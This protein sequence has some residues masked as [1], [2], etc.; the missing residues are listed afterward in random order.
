MHV[1]S[2]IMPFVH[3]FLM[4]FP[5]FGFCPGKAIDEAISRVIK[6]CSEVRERLKQGNCGVFARRQ[7]RRPTSCYGGAQLS[8]DLS[9]AFDL[10]PRQVMHDALRIM[11]V[12]EDLCILILHLHETSKYHVEHAGR[13]ASF[14]MKRG[15]RQ[16]CTLA[17]TLFAAFMVYFSHLLASRT[18]SAWVEK[19]PTMFAD[20]TH[21]DWLIDSVDSMHEMAKFV[22]ETYTLFQELGMK[23]NPTKSVLVIRVKGRAAKSWIKQR[24]LKKKKQV[25]INLGTVSDPLL[26]PLADRTVY[27]GVVISYSNFEMQTVQH[28]IQVSSM[29]RQRLIKILHSSRTIDFQHRLRL[30]CACARSSTAYGVHAVG[31]TSKSLNRL[32]QYEIRHFRASARSPVHLTREPNDVFLRRQP[33]QEYFRKLLQGR[34]KKC[35]NESI[36][37]H[38]AKVLNFL[39]QEVSQDTEMGDRS[40]VLFPIAQNAGVSCPTCGTH[41]LDQSSMRKHHAKKHKISSVN[42]AG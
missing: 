9:Q 33:I 6:H 19:F 8:V 40:E 1:K 20:D 35:Q 21:S 10:L 22:R 38:F 23:V 16:G 37:Q 32:Q 28:R 42:P 7:G 5:Q 34:I 25:L 17:P 13:G 15:V 29:H 31:F 14:S 39:T 27:L 12:P 24:V 26:I 30:Y 11:G 2:L 18:S 3:P 36:Q 41:F 4:A